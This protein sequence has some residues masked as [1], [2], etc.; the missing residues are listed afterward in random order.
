[1]RP[2]TPPLVIQGRVI[3]AVI[4]REMR[5]RF[6]RA[7]LGYVWALAEPVAHVAT[8]LTIFTLLGRVAPVGNDLSLFFVT[9][10]VPWLMFSN[11]VSRTMKAVDANSALLSYPQVMPIDLMVARSLLEAAT[12]VTVFGVLLAVLGS[13]GSTVTPYNFLDLLGAFFCITVFATGIG[14]ANTV[15]STVW[16]SYEKI[17]AAL[18]RPLYF[19]SGVFFTADM[20]PSPAREWMLLNPL[21]HMV[22]WTRSGFFPDYDGSHLDRVFAISIAAI[23]LLLGLAAERACRNRLRQA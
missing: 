8:L 19:L 3:L 16:P 21:L 11:V 1:V 15:V 13:T 20:I 7:Q 18:T 22:E 14:M 10:I 5:T 23:L 4:L 17:Y 2:P 9:G 12:M 6:G